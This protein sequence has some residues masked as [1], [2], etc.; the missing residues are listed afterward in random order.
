VP[1]LQKGVYGLFDTCE[2]KFYSSETSVPFK[3]TVSERNDAII[4]KKGITYQRLEY[5]QND[6]TN[7][8][9]TGIILN[10]DRGFKVETNFATTEKTT[11][12]GDKRCCIA[13][14][15]AGIAGDTANDI[16][17]EVESEQ[18]RIYLDGEQVDLKNNNINP[19]S[20][21]N[22]AVFT[23]FAGV[24]TNTLNGKTE[25]ISKALSGDA[26]NSL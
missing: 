11:H 8:I 16:S 3:G 9:D 2:M 12:I 17:I 1:A 5:I 19:V 13:S 21:I 24:T 4:Y 20:D 10:F 7:Y 23:H 25:T 22:T 26:G 18:S 6:K 14:N 15:H